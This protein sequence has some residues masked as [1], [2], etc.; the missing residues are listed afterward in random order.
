M[1]FCSFITFCCITKTYSVSR[2]RFYLAE[3]FCHARKKDLGINLVAYKQTQKFSFFNFLLGKILKFQNWLF[4]WNWIF[5]FIC[6]KC[7]LS[8]CSLQQL[9]SIHQFWRFPVYLFFRDLVMMASYGTYVNKK[10]KPLPVFPTLS[11][12]FVFSLSNHCKKSKSN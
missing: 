5:F 6:E 9:D 11:H 4:F 3:K 12:S 10:I 1:I 7:S 8:S 2:K